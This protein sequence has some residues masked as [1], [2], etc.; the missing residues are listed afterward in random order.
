LTF[1][2]TEVFLECFYETA[3]FTL[4]TRGCWLRSRQP[5][6]ATGGSLSAPVWVWQQESHSSDPVHVYDEFPATTSEEEIKR[7]MANRLAE[8]PFS[9]DQPL[10]QLCPR[11]L[12]RFVTVRCY[13]SESAWIDRSFFDESGR[14]TYDVYT[15]HENGD[16]AGL[17]EIT[18]A[19]TKI[20]EYLRRFQPVLYKQVRNTEAPQQASAVMA[21]LT[22]LSTL[23]RASSAFGDEL[24]RPTDAQLAQVRD[25]R[26]ADWQARCEEH[27]RKLDQIVDEHLERLCQSPDYKDKWVVLTEDSPTPLYAADTKLEALKWKAATWKERNLQGTPAFIF[28]AAK[29][30]RREEF[31]PPV[32]V[33]PCSYNGSRITT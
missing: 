28:L 5:L 20:M 7:Y 14:Q 21:V 18:A 32:H 26:E 15:F 27:D 3:A 11:F 12:A 2:K 1:Q 13:L 33:H 10:R 16:V 8:P 30:F 23:E 31:S 6:S 22:E 29:G 17:S 4:L 25:P 19:P 24:P 9:I